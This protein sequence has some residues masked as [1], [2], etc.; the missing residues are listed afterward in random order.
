[1]AFPP[2]DHDTPIGAVLAVMGNA[3]ES[4]GGYGRNHRARG[5]S[6]VP[7]STGSGLRR[8][9]EMLTKNEQGK[10]RPEVCWSG[11]SEASPTRSQFPP[12]PL[13][14]LLLSGRKTEGTS[15]P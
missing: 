5:G 14:A 10:E 1:M 2:S 13:A 12:L 9:R 6:K 15:H 11:G 7:P 4:A 3:L 8:R